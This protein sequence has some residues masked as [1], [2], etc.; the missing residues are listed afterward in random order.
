MRR[1]RRTIKLASVSCL[2]VG[3]G[4]L[5]IDIETMAERSGRDC[6][7]SQLPPPFVAR[8]WAISSSVALCS[9]CS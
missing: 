2:T 3:R 7:H 8:N 4:M 1:A 5:C 6:A 9:A